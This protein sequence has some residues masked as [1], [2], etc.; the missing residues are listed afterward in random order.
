MRNE[1]TELIKELPRINELAKIA[2][3]RDLTQEELKERDI[4]RK[5]YL[6]AVRCATN[7]MIL[8]ST[9]VDPEGNDVTPLKLK[10]VQRQLRA[11]RS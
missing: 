10:E 8:N 9:V 2:K 6:E 1:E 4:L 11:T 7:N 3:E 5:K